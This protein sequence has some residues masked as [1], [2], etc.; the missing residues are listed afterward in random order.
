MLEPLS[1]HL[2]RFKDVS[3]S[4]GLMLESLSPR[5]MLPGG[6]HHDCPDKEPGARMATLEAAGRAG[7]PFTTGECQR[8]GCLNERRCRDGRREVVDYGIDWGYLDLNPLLR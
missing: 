4:Q 7:V 3:A 1:S 8:G 6:A 2:S 5:L